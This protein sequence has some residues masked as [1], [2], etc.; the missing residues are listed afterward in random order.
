[1]AVNSNGRYPTGRKFENKDR[2][3]VNSTRKQYNATEKY[4]EDVVSTESSEFRQRDL[5]VDLFPL[6]L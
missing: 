6:I 3:G 5:L 2:T 1:M 4:A